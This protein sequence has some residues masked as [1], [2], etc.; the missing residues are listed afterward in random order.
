[1]SYSTFPVRVDIVDGEKLNMT[2]IRKNS[3]TRRDKNYVNKKIRN[4]GKLMLK[5]KVL[6][7]AA[8]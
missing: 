8:S 4:Q 6:A 7:R 1:M 2:E 3:P 5:I